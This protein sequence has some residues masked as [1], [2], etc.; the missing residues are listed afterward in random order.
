ME[1]PND[2]PLG[3]VAD[4]PQVTLLG[5]ADTAVVRALSALVA[6]YGLDLCHLA[7]AATIPGS[8]WGPPEA[9]LRGNRLF[10]R[11]DT[12]L[13]SALH[14]ACHFLCMAEARR[15]ALDT[16]ASGDDLEECA[17][18]YLSLLL[19]ELLPGYSQAAMLRDMDRWGYS[20]RLGSAAAWFHHDAAD[21]RDWLQAAG[22]VDAAGRL[23]PPE[24][25]CP[26]RQR[27]NRLR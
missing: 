7:A 27:R 1:V 4:V 16:D 18:C 10:V 13:H 5:A 22:W 9:G 6:R 8:Y 12:P 11:P 2:T 23:M 14:E 17:V 24:A 3:L 26:T 19:A 15:E 20:F 25:R 21:A